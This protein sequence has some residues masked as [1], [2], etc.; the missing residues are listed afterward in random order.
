MMM[1]PLVYF[2]WRYPAMVRDLCIFLV[3]G[4]LWEEGSDGWC[5]YEIWTVGRRNPPTISLTLNGRM[6]QVITLIP[7]PY[8]YFINGQGTDVD[9]NYGILCLLFC[10]ALFNH[11]IKLTLVHSLSVFLTLTTYTSA[12][13]FCM[14]FYSCIAESFDHVQELK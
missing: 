12:D 3:S 11:H 5:K 6:L 10:K 9:Y 14:T 1:T 7:S 2:T 13:K 8:N 4:G